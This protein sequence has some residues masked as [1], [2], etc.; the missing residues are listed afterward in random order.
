MRSVDQNAH[1]YAT[2]NSSVV[3]WWAWAQRKIKEMVSTDGDEHQ[4]ITLMD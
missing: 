2:G 4:E 3:Q 1:I